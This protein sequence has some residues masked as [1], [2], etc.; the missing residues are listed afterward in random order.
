MS[1]FDLVINGKIR[2]GELRRDAGRRRLSAAGSRSRTTAIRANAR[3]AA[4]TSSSGQVDDR[5]TAEKEYR[6]RLPGQGDRQRGDRVRSCGGCRQAL[7]PRS[8]ASRRLPPTS[9]KYRSLLDTPIA[10]RPGQYLSVK[11]AGFPARDLSPTVR[12]DGTTAPGELIFHIRR[13]PGGLVSTQIG[14]TIRVRASRAGAR[15]VRKRVPARGL[16]TDRADRRRHRLGAD[17][18]GRGGRAA[19]TA[20]SRAHRDRR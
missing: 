15:P 1:S 19:R 9:S 6:P 10:M 12:F 4:S 16:R 3:R 17:L 8:P 7:R 5:G 18:V 2:Q 13:Y 20:P 14:A 11:F